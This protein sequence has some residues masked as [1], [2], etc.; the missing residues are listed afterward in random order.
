VIQEI[1][2]L[3]GALQTERREILDKIDLLNTSLRQ[4]EYR[5]G[6]HMRLDP[7]QARDSEIAEFQDSLK[8][9]LA[10]TFEG[11]LEADEARYLRIEK[12]LTRLREDLHWRDRVTDV[13]RWFDFGVQE[14]DRVSVPRNTSCEMR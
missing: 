14:L 8:Q 1:G 11:T 10:G 9:C 2:L 13:R 7:R 4:L 3:N 5:P 6:T 12:L